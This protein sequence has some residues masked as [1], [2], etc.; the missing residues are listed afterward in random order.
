[1]LTEKSESYYLDPSYTLW[2]RVSSRAE[3]IVEFY[4]LD[5]FDGDEPVWVRYTGGNPLNNQFRPIGGGWA[6]QVLEV[7]RKWNKRC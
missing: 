7:A 1:M 5:R 2:K 6:M 4:F 3:T